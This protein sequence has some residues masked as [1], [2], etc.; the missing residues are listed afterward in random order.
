MSPHAGDEDIV[1]RGKVNT[2]G[3]T[4]CLFF[5]SRGFFGPLLI[6]LVLCG[7]VLG[8]IAELKGLWSRHGFSFLLEKVISFWPE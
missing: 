6:L 5:G 2:Q 8:E 3:L 1:A 7:V 4:C